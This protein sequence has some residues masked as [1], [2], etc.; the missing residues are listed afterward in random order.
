MKIRA[1]MQR[2]RLKAAALAIISGSILWRLVNLLWSEESYK[3]AK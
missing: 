3:M 1:R 2:R